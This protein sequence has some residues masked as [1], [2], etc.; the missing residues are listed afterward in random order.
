MSNKETTVAE[1]IWEDIKDVT[2]NMFAL[3]GQ[4]AATYLVPVIVEPTKLYLEFKDK[5]ATAVLPAL[6][7]AVGKKYGVSVAGRFIC[8]AP[9]NKTIL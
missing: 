1:K 3:P 9:L 4:T 8:V 2:L 6:E 5:N 7:D